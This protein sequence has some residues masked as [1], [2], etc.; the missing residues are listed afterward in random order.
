MGETFKV[1]GSYRQVEI[2]GYVNPSEMHRFCLG[3]LSNVHRTEA[4]EKA[5]LVTPK[6]IFLKSVSSLSLFNKST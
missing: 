2:D 6:S 5:R 3:Q 4:S 1:M